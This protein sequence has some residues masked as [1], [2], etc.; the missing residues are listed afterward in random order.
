MN[1]F[2]TILLLLLALPAWAQTTLNVTDFG[3]RGDAVQ[4]SVNTTSNSVVVTTTNQLSSADIGKAI[5]VFGAGTATTPPNCQ[6]MVATITNVVSGTNIYVSQLVQRTLT[7]TFATYGHNNRTNFANAIAAASGTNTIINIPAGKY[8]FLSTYVSNLWAS[9]E[10]V[11]YGGGI[12]FVGAGTNST[13]LLSQGAWTLQNGAAWRGFLIT[14]VN[15]VTN[16]Y[17]VSFGNMTLDG[18]VQQGN[19][20]NHNF[21]ASI[22]DGAGWD[23]TSDAID[24]RGGTGNTFTHQLW[25]NLLFIHW[26]GEIVKSNDGSTNGNLSIFNCAFTDGN[27]SAINIYPS[28]NISNCVFDNL[29]Q[30]AEYY[31]KYSTNTSYF[32]NNLVTNITGNQFAINGGKG[33]NPAFVIQGNT[34]YFS[35]MGYNGIETVPADNVFIISNQFICQNGVHS[36][37]IDL[38]C[39]GYQGYFDNSNIVIAYNNFVEPTMIVELAN[40]P[41]NNAE[42]VQVYSNTLLRT[43]GNTI[44]LQTYNWSTNIH[45]FN[46]DFSH[47]T[48]GYVTFSSGSYG[49]QYVLVDTNNLYY[50][51]IYDSTGKTNYISYANGSRFEVIY[52]FHAGTVYALTDTNANQ[53]PAGAQILILNSNTSS[54]SIPVYLNSA[55]TRGPINVASGQ[56]FIASWTNGVWMSPSIVQPIILT[57]ATK[58]PNGAF[59]F[60]FTNTPGVTNY[61]TTNTTTTITTNWSTRGPPRITGYTTNITTTLTTNT[62]ENTVTVLTTTNLLLPLTN[63]TVLGTVTDSP[64][65]H[66]QF[67]DPQAINH[68]LR[69]YR[70]RS[71]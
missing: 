17:P 7:N 37:L 8:L 36:Q 18:G 47:I 27:A 33:N 5:E 35:A 42:A 41:P 30:V 3:A 2:V 66:F 64:P 49:G 9:V 59:Q 52:P 10:I 44:A 4:F 16:D 56:T 21:P 12:H 20:G 61:I 40:G 26:R 14:I 67:T 23:E 15:P 43:T 34:F 29:L 48:N 11:L 19:T 13:T 31:Q 45:F 58:L 46:N 69:F 6:D 24:I 39:P 51:P 60:A 63:W 1:L 50:S 71:P 68:P 62:S 53:I 65:G 55:L 70:V 32:V 54:A 28:L 38:G 57:G 22:V 25:T